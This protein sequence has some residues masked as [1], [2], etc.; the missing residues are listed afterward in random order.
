MDYVNGL[1]RGATRI[2]SLVENSGQETF[3]REQVL[4]LCAGVDLEADQE[5]TPAMGLKLCPACNGLVRVPRE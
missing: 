2:R 4:Q 1:H 5:V 3:T